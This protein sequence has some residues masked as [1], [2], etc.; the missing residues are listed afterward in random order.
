MPRI[1][2]VLSFSLIAAC[3]PRGE[4][5]ALPP[6][7]AA[8]QATQ[9]VFVGTT[10]GFDAE[11]GEDFGIPRN[12]QPRF[13]RYD[14]SVPLDRTPG[15]IAW[16]K[17][18]ETPDPARHFLAASQRIYEGAAPFRTDLARELRTNRRGERE[19]IVFVHGFNSTFAEGLYRV[20]QLGQDLELPGVSVHYAWPSRANPLAYA[21][22]RDSALFARD[23]FQEL[24]GEVAAAGAER[25][26]IVA[27]SMGSALT[28]EML[29]QMAISGDT[30]IRSR[31]AGVILI[32]PDIDIDVFRSQ[33]ARIGVLP[34]PFVI[35]TS[36][37]DRALQLSAR[38][39]GQRERLGNLRT[40][41]P[42]ADLEVTLLDISAFSE[43]LGHFAVGD[44]PALLRILTRVTDMDSAFAGDRTGRTGLLPGAVL[45]VQNATQIVLSPVAIIGGAGR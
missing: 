20:A 39:T 26:I 8:P 30:A 14:I 40:V 10:R 22:D 18:N 33:A 1:L 45:T 27:H 34:Q 36:Q 38:L 32:S 21:Y 7:A 3:S 25:I 15:E 43:G 35:F 16:P 2:L 9:T 5:T 11:T 44:S 12:P 41:D 31:L 28:M 37:K 13:A 23:G 4:I 24:M 42:V 6:A 19:V 17:P 29:R